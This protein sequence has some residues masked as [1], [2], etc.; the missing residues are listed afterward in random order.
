MAFSGCDKLRD[1]PFGKAVREKQPLAF[2]N[3]RQVY[4]MGYWDVD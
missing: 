1:T 3:I 2:H 4:E